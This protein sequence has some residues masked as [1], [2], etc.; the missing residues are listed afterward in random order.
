MQAIKTKGK[1]HIFLGTTLKKGIR[2]KKKKKW[3]KR[4]S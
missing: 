3:K 1:G 2:V 4:G